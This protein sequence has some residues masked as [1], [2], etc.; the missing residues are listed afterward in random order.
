MSALGHALRLARIDVTRTRRKHTDWRGGSGGTSVVGALLYGVLVAVGTVGGGYAAVRAGRTLAGGDPLAGLEAFTLV[1]VVRG[2]L[3]LFWLMVTLVYALRA[4]G[5]RGTLTEPEGV[6]T[7]VPTRQALL[8]VLLAEYAYFLLWLL[9]PAVGVGAGLAVGAGA[10]WP[11]VAVPLGV[12]VA[13]VGSV[14]VGYVLGLSI[15]HV[16]SRF[17]FVARHKGAIVLVVFVAYFVA[18][19]S[20]AWNE[21]VVRLFEP[22]QGSPVG[23]YAD[24]ALLGTPSVEASVRNAAGAVALTAVLAA[25]VLVGGTRVAARHWFSDPVLAGERVLP[26]E[27]DAAPGV[28][29]RLEPVLGSGTAALVVLSWRRAR[30]SPLRLLYAFYPL[31]LLAGLFADIVQSG[32]VPSYLPFAILLFA[33]WAAGVVFTL[34]P[35]GD[36]G[37]A[38]ASTLL[39][40]VDGRTFVRAHLVAGLVVAVPLG[41]VAT[42]VVTALSPLAGQP[43]TA[44]VAATPVVMVLS[45]VVS[46]GIGTA[47]PRFEATTVTR[48]MKTVLPSKW[49]FALFTLYLFLTAAAGTVVYDPVVRDVGAALLTWALPLGLR[50]SPDALDLVAS[51]ALVPLALAPVA[52]YRYAVRRFD[53]FTLG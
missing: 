29:R 36:Q 42:A 39:S 33:A 11:A 9:L 13:G 17:S 51:A 34:N 24:L 6:L 2:V 35:L 20:G 38:L 12:A 16:A 10:V 19:S 44:L 32:R 41:T 15:R 27:R 43:A 21:L 25:A 53:R 48:S 14:G 3:A 22:M 31:L 28:E 18:L 52:A 4:V 7:V 1:E 23:W 37:A 45:A 50:V 5:Q 30:R 47:F 26:D 40:E 49:A 8:G 46:V